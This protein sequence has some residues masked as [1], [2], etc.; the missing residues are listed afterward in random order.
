[1][2][3][4]KSCILL[5]IIPIVFHDENSKIH[6]ILV[7]LL[8]FHFEISGKDNNDEYLLSKKLISVSL[9]VFH[10]ERSNKDN[11][12]LHSLIILLKSISLDYLSDNDEH[13]K[14]KIQYY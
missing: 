1:M 10:F 5:L 8:I 14:K 13:S 6:F 7:M 3:I 11:N 2:S 12:N 9:L 4:C